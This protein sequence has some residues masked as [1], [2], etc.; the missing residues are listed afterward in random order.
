MTMIPRCQCGEP[1]AL[2]AEM[3]FEQI[4]TEVPALAQV[5]IEL[6]E[7]D[8]RWR[9]FHCVSCDCGCRRLVPVETAS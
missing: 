8:T 4:E 3:A 5:M 9:L 1:M 7:L 2:Q 6:D